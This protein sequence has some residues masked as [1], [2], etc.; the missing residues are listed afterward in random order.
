[1]SKTL[2]VSFAAAA[3][4]ATLLPALDRADAATAKEPPKTSHFR[5]ALGGG[6]T[7]LLYDSTGKFLTSLSPFEQAGGVNV[8][9][10]DINGD[11]VADL[12]TGHASGPH[13]RVFDGRTLKQHLAV[14]P[15]GAEFKGGISVAA[16]D[17]NGDGKADIITGAGPG[18]GPHVRVFDGNGATTH[19]FDA[20][21]AEFKGGVRVATGDLNGDGVAELIVTAAAG[22]GSVRPFDGA[23]GRAL[24]SFTPFGEDYKGGINLAAG[25]F[26]GQ[27]ALFASKIAAGDGSVRVIS[28][29]RGAEAFDFKPFGDDY[30]GELSLSFIAGAKGDSL[31]VG[32]KQ[33]GTVGIFTLSAPIAGDGLLAP[34]PF[35]T[36]FFFK[37]FGE[38]YS[39]GISVAAFGSAVPEPA[40]WA[41]MI[42]GF[43]LVGAASRRR[44]Q[45]RGGSV[46]PA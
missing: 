5:M 30:Q 11:G 7:T 41:M 22:D 19:A 2:T 35:S 46:N 8:A 18:A 36:G 32:Q 37:P 21:D 20:F 45:A 28:L 23:T 10:G 1:M 13:V 40:S 39:G 24:G 29:S 42:G 27:N 43:G 25:K 33:G 16:G 3:A 6:E 26:L 12:V 14:D 31:V 9:A 44:L 15:F 4:A 17:V 38:N 34:A